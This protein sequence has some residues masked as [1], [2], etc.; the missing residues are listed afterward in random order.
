MKTFDWESRIREWS[1]QRI[2]ALEEYEQEKLPPEVI[3]SGSLGYSGATEDEISAAEARLGVTFPSSYREFLKV[4]NGLHSISE[5]GFRFYSVEE[6]EWYII[7]EES[8]IE[9]IW[10]LI[11]R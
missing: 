5:Y 9:P 3:E 6:I 11:Y 7:G 1:R 2:E 8:S 10:Y 4:S